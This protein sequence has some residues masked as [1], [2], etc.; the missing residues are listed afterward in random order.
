[1][2]PDQ[3]TTKFIF[4]LPSLAFNMILDF[5][6]LSAPVTLTLLYITIPFLD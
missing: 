5:E 4:I 6:D 2:T 1:M 3:S